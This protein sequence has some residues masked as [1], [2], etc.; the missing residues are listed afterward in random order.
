MQHRAVAFYM[1][2]CPSLYELLVSSGFKH[3][4]IGS[5]RKPLA[6]GRLTEEDAC[7]RDTSRYS[8]FWS[9]NT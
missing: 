3:S 2:S 6:V 4:K 7:A 9:L 1:F 5:I 8:Y